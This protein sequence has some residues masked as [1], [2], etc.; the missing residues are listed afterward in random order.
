MS[1]DI[2]DLIDAAIGCGHCGGDL[3]G[4]PSE[5]FCGEACQEGWNAGRAEAL[6][7]E[8]GPDALHA[9]HTMALAYHAMHRPRPAAVMR[10]GRAWIDGADVADVAEAFLGASG[11]TLEPFQRHIL[12]E[13]YRAP[14][15]SQ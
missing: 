8:G 2:I 1:T 10:R 4:S 14:R 5:Y 13:I 7:V 12:N 3:A 9:M 11:I 6:P 15:R